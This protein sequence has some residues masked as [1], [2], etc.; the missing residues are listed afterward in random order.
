[1]ICFQEKDLTI[2]WFS[3]IKKNKL[4]K[5]VNEMKIEKYFMIN[6]RVYFSNI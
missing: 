5:T 3:K 2:K 6:F 1:M 4:Y